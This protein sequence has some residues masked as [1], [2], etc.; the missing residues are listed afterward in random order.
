M[1]SRAPALFAALALCLSGATATAAPLKVPLPGGTASVTIDD[2]QWRRDSE[3]DGVVT[4][5]CQ[6]RD[7]PGATLLRLKREVLKGAEAEL[8]EK[9]LFETWNGLTVNSQEGG[10]TTKSIARARRKNV[11]AVR[12]V[13][14]RLAVKSSSGSYETR[15][16]WVPQG[17]SRLSV[18]VITRQPVRGDILARLQRMVIPTL[19]LK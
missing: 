3:E 5:V 11:G 1:S 8:S 7:C 10:F 13:E 16:F 6:R 14:L 18:N 19:E 15:L 17:H 12:G 2:T 9:E 4:Y